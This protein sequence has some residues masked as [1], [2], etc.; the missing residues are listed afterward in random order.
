M[1]TVLDDFLTSSQLSGKKVSL[2]YA[3]PAALRS[4]YGTDLHLM[5]TI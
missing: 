3:S 4:D 1:T 2:L 5:E